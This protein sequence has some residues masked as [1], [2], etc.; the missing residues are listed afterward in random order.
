MRHE[1][2][3]PYIRIF[4]YI[5]IQNNCKGRQSWRHSDGGAAIGGYG[6]S[7]PMRSNS[8]FRRVRSLCNSAS[9]S[10]KKASIRARSIR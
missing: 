6:N 4:A 7:V 5:T 9:G 10:A 2:F 1:A 3:N 8:T